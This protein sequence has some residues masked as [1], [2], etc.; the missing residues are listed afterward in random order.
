LVHGDCREVL[1]TL[2]DSCADACITDPPYGVTSLEWDVAVEG[3]LPEVDRVLKPEG[4]LWVFGSMRS[5]APVIADAEKGR[6]GPWRYAQEIVWEKHNGSGFQADRFR[7]VHEFAAHFY[8]GAW[9]SVYRSPVVTLDA[10]A[11]TV[12][13]KRRPKHMGQIDRTAYISHDGG[14]RL[15]RSV[16]RV[17]SEHGRAEHPTQKPVG[18][19]LP[20][21]EYSCPLGGTVLDPFAGAGSTGVA[22]HELGREAILIEID[23]DYYAAAERRT[24]QTS[25]VLE[26]PA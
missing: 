7:R 2:T 21:I 12:R 18:I 26:V 10:K 8:R 11:R 23:P 1:P 17:R 14:P 20:L 22:A 15:Q 4:S 19:L 5:L 3:W 6:L 9:G 16:I 13:S 24:N 25:F